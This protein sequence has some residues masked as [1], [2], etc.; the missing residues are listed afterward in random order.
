L[1]PRFLGA[2]MPATIWPRD[3]FALR[4]DAI[5]RSSRRVASQA[6]DVFVC[7]PGQ[8]RHMPV[9]R[10]FTRPA[11]DGRLPDHREGAFR[12]CGGS[13]VRPG[14]GSMETVNMATKKYVAEA[15][16]T[17]WLTFA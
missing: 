6:D 12:R 8:L 14:E 5:P 13:G 3:S 11:V 9:A 7:V 16:G 1:S 2:M 17:F 10:A 15:I 4:P